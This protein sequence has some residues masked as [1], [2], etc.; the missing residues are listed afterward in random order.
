[1]LER[2]LHTYASSVEGNSS[3]SSGGSPKNQSRSDDTVLGPRYHSHVRIFIIVIMIAFSTAGNSVVCWK[4]LTRRRRRCLSKAQVLFLNLAVADL[5][6]TLVTMTSQMVWE[7]MGRIWVAGDAFCRMFKVLQTFALASST[8]VI[9]SIALDRHSAIVS[10]LAKCPGPW[11]LATAAWVAAL[12][13][14]LPN[15]YVFRLIK[16]LRMTVLVFGAFIVTNVPY[17]V[18]EMVLAFSGSSG[19]LSS[20][21]VAL[22]GVISASNSAINPYIYILFHTRK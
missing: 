6:V 10:P 2:I 21:I 12:M 8:Y 3:F 22:F 1:M 4:L 14:S 7:I 16:T 17:M 13:P 11:K 9:V 19:A 20:S 15:I 18:Q 5:L